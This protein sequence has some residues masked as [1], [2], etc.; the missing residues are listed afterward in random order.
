MLTHEV[1]INLNVFSAFV[2]DIIVANIDHNFIN[3]V[4]RHGLL[5]RKR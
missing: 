5:D 1:R 3:T 2:G 4:E